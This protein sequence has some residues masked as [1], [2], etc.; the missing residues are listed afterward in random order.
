MVSPLL[1]LSDQQ[2]EDL[3]DGCGRCCLVKLEDEDSGEIA[4]T[5]VACKFFNDQTCRCSDYTNRA[6]IN[7]RCMVLGKDRLDILEVMPFTCAYRLVHEGRQ[8]DQ[9]AETLKVTGMTVSEE[10]IHDDQLVLHIVD[11]VSVDG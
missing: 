2:W 7:P 8:L 9:S 1:S 10:Y 3:C 5:N 4:Y 6:D 11:W